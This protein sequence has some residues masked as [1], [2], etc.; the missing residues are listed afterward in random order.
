MKEKLN[1]IN[2]KERVEEDRRSK[3]NG[4]GKGAN[5]C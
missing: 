4:R 1:S 3:T 5:P 2:Q